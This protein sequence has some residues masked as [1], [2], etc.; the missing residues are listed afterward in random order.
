M[1]KG[2]DAILSEDEVKRY[3]KLWLKKSKSYEIVDVNYGRKK[4]IDI[5]AY[6]KNSKKEWVIEA[7]GSGSKNKKYAQN[8]RYN[9]Y[10]LGE[11]LQKMDKNNV[12]YSI[13]V[14]LYQKY[15]RLWGELPQIAKKRLK[16]SIIFVDAKGRCKE[17]D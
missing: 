8:A 5:H 15:E 1:D 13:A 2:N 10:F 4:G 17:V 9:N 16:L 6:M 7:K 12:K 3:V 14:P 11:L